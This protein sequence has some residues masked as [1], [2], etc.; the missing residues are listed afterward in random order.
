MIMC[1][2]GM[3]LICGSE[4]KLEFAHKTPDH[5]KGMGRGS[6]KRIADVQSHPEHYLLLC[7]YCYWAY[8]SN[9]A[10]FIALHKELAPLMP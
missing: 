1:F 7:K 8:D 6:Y 4:Q 3:C 9:P 2:G 5:L 10:G